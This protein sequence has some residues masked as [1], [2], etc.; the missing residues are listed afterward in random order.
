MAGGR[1]EAGKLKLLRPVNPVNDVFNA[2]GI[3]SIKLLIFA[4]PL[5][6]LRA[7]AHPDGRLIN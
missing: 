1:R 6:L 4:P 5:W 3:F 2:F 7:A